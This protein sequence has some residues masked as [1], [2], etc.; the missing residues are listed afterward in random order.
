VNHRSLP[1]A[2]ALTATAALLL[3]ACSGSEDKPKANDKIAGA[4]QGEKKSAS[5][6]TSPS[7]AADRPEIELP[8]DVVDTFDPEKSGDPV[9]DAILKDNADFVR[10]LDAAIVAGNPNLPALEFYTEGEAAVAAQKWV[11]S[12]KDAGR[13]V[14]GTTRYYDRKV[15]IK[16]KKSASI[17]YCADESRGFSK[18]IKTGKVQ[19]TKVTKNSYLA[20]GAQVQLN[21]AGVWE[22]IKMSSARGA[23]SCQP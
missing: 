21:D 23:S 6:T 17:S 15:N 8:T 20:Y 2:A 9:Q 12:F 7:P 13:T 11:K 3:T 18:D 22:L 5:P 19:G 10:S 1:I 4:D 16:S 14:T